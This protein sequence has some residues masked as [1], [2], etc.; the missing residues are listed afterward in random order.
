MKSLMMSLIMISLLSVA[1]IAF[2]DT[3]KLRMNISG[4]AKNTYLCINNLGCY[5]VGPE[6][7]GKAFPV[8]LVN[9]EYLAMANVANNRLYKQ[10][11]PASCNVNVNANQTLVVSGHVTKSAN[12]NMVI[13]GL[14]CSV[15]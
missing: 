10:V 9:V 3:A 7:Q 11:L 14:N 15:V 8:D 5:K 4:N 6:S 2:A 13:H 12:D 1:N